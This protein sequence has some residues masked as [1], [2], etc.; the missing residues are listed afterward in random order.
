MFKV[1][2]KFFAGHSL[3]LPERVI[4]L[5]AW[6]LTLD[7]V[8]WCCLFLFSIGCFVSISL[9]Q[10]SA[11]TG[12]AI[13]MV[14]LKLTRSWKRVQLPLILPF[15]L[16]AGASILSVLLA[17]D[18][19]VSLPP[20]KKLLEI[21]IFFWVL[22][23]LRKRNPTTVFKSFFSQ[24]RKNYRSIFESFQ[25]SN[26]EILV[27]LCTGMG[28]LIS[29]YCFYLAFQNGIERPYRV[30]GGFDNPISWGVVLMMLSLLAGTHI[31]HSSHK[32]RI[33]SCAFFFLL[34]SCLI[35]TLVREAWLGFIV[36]LT[37]M[38]IFRKRILAL[39]AP[40]AFI[41]ILVALP[42]NIQNRLMEMKDLNLKTFQLRLDMWQA[43]WEVFKDYPIVGCGF[44][45]TRLI[46]S[47]YPKHQRV[48]EYWAG[49]LHNNF[50]QIAVDLGLVGLMTWLGIWA[51]FFWQTALKLRSLKPDDPNRWIIHGS[52]WSVLAFLIACLFESHFYDTEVAMILFMVMALPFSIKAAPQ[53]SQQIN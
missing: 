1:C 8:Q 14:Q 15:A 42:G 23:V 25:S 51:A 48:L 5:R 44:R 28:A 2:Q 30:V 35:I 17:V 22:N 36:A 4:K 33:V 45:C 37:A 26:G 7:R 9:A 39:I 52:I 49:G 24:I 47:D 38:L 20:L 31:I 43:G 34:V 19:R 41:F 32:G 46:A 12:F 21:L 10:I 27:M 11:L 6:C 29:T 40:F 18:W 50:V 13:W 16:F 53:S 3:P